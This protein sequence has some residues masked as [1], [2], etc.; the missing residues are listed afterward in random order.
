[1]AQSSFIKNGYQ[2]GFE[3][4]PKWVRVMLG[5]EFIA[6]SKGVHLLIP[7]GPPF[8][9]FPKDDIRMELLQPSDYTEQSPILGDATYWTIKVGDRITHD[10]VF[11]YPK[12]ISGE[13]DLSDYVT[14]VWDKM[15]AWFEE[16]EE[17]FVHPHDPYHRIDVLESRRHVRVVIS[18]ENVAESDKP[19]LLFETGL[20]TRY[21]LPKLDVRMDL[22]E[23]SNTV[24]GCAYKGEAQYY[25]V[26]VDDKVATDIAW[27]Y[28]YPTTETAKI[29]GRICFF[30]E[31]VDALYVDGVKQPKPKTKW[32]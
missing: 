11:T 26:R 4:S 1:M 21:Y 10:A 13:L 28:R 25:S 16:A 6:D 30:N 18:G 23:P 31:R 7:G 9:Y 17:V 24:T 3:L 19:I 2:I 27:Y 8:Y 29:A 14:F 32:S 15:D 5:G 22:L 12:H 20:P